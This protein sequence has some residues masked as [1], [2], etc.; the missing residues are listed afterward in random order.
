MTLN[1]F[2]YTKKNGEKKEY[3]LLV[4][5][6][7]ETYLAGIDLNKLTEKEKEELFVIQQEYEEKTKPFVNK[8]FRNFIKEN[9]EEI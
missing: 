1:K 6:E 3:D 5:K 4:L 7:S 2:N 8:G 9:I